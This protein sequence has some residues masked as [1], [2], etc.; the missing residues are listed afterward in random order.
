MRTLVLNSVHCLGHAKIENTQTSIKAML[1]K[2]VYP[3]GL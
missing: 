3:N 2:N 1:A